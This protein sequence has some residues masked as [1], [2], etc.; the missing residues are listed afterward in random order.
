MGCRKREGV[1]IITFE[2][3]VYTTKPEHAFVQRH[4]KIELSMLF[5]VGG[6]PNFFSSFISQC[7]G[8]PVRGAGISYFVE[9]WRHAG[10]VEVYWDTQGTGRACSQPNQ[11]TIFCLSE[12][13]TVSTC[14]LVPRYSKGP[15]RQ[16]RG[17]VYRQY[18]VNSLCDT[19]VFD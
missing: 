13:R 9:S 8:V 10:W 17:Q 12:A 2:S 19:A 18:I 16:W 14:F 7:F 11:P 15:K 3:F 6:C 1:N 5:Q 4:S